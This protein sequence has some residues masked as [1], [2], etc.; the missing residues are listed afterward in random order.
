MSPLALA[1]FQQWAARLNAE[2]TAKRERYRLEHGLSNEKLIRGDLT[3]SSSMWWRLR[4]QG[5]SA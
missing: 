3:G 4:R 2:H 1:A 5:R